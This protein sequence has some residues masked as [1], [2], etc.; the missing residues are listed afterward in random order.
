M[1]KRVTFDVLAL[2]KAE[3]FDE[4]GRKVKKLGDDT[5]RDMHLLSTA[6]AGLGPALVPLTA[7]VAAAALG[8]GA[9]GAVGLL[10]FGGIKREMA[11]GTP[12]GVRYT[13]MVGELKGDLHDL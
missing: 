4:T 7:G 11:A 8:V 5:K 1:S 6:I 3:G 9:L 10:A 13:S 2:A 12:V